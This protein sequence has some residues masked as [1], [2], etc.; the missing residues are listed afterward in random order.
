MDRNRFNKLMNNGIIRKSKKKTDTAVLL[1]HGFTG[2]AKTYI[3]LIKHLSKQY[4]VYAPNLPGHA[5]TI[6]N[7]KLQT[8][9]TWLDDP[10]KLYKIIKRKYPKVIIGGLSM[11][12]CIALYIASKEKPYKVFTLSTPI[13]LF[14]KSSFKLGFKKKLTFKNINRIYREIKKVRKRIANVGYLKSFEIAANQIYRKILE[15]NAKRVKNKNFKKYAKA[16]NYVPY[17][18]LKELLKL[19]ALVRERL[20]MVKAPLLVIH[21]TKDKIVPIS[22]VSNLLRNV[23]SDETERLIVRKS[24]HNVLLDEDE[25]IVEKKIIEFINEKC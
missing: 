2:R 16:Y 3:P 19:V 5:S 6:E 9:R 7:F 25:E 12:S 8:H 24:G 10:H 4:D 13:D 18:S 22:N 23:G 17:D 11:G 21:S 15:H 14:E 20:P 1:L